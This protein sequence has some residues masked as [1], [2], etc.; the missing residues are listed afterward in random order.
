MLN[1]ATVLAFLIFGGQMVD[2]SWV[3]PHVKQL[4]DLNCNRRDFFVGSFC[5]DS[6]NSCWSYTRWRLANLYSPCVI[7]FIRALALS[8]AFARSQTCLK[9][10]VFPSAIASLRKLFDS[11]PNTRMSL[12]VLSLTVVSCPPSSIS[13]HAFEFFDRHVSL[14]ETS[15]L[16]PC[17]NLVALRFSL[18]LL[19]R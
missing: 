19:C 11:R 5:F 10:R 7:I 18:S 9:V 3:F 17:E 14:L 1:L 4:L 8:S 6:V 2:L 12:K 13:N 16:I 15:E